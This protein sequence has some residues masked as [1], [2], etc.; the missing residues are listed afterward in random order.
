MEKLREENY[1]IQS[2]IP[3]NVTIAKKKFFSLYSDPNPPFLIN[4]I[5][6]TVFFI[7]VFP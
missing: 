2:S 6:F 1:V 3:P 5:N 4:V 7:A